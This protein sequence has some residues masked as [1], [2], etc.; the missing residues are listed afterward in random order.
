[1]LECVPYDVIKEL[2]FRFVPDFKFYVD[3]RLLGG[4]VL[5]AV[6]GVGWYRYERRQ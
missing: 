2:V 1:M 5:V 3:A 6:G 4:L